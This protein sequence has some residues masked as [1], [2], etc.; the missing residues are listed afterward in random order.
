[1]KWL[2]NALATS[3]GKKFVMGLTGLLLCGFL[4]VHL[5]GNLL[6]YVGAD[7]YNHYAHSLHE[8]KALL[9]VAEIGLLLLFLAHIVLAIRLTM[10]NRAARKSRYLVQVSK[11]DGQNFNKL[12]G[13][14]AWMFVSG[15][16]VLGFILLHLVDFRF[17][18]RSELVYEGKEPFQKALMVL[19]TPL[20]FGVYIVG[21]LFLGWHL[22]HGFAS[23]FQSLGINHPKYNGLI[24]GVSLV[25][26]IAIALGF[27]SFPLW[28]WLSNHSSAA[29]L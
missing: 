1:M 8:Q 4:V 25:F 13:A 23:A 29:G 2:V 10:E 18:L 27:A 28:A 3:I 11:I 22:S 16:I 17:E 24:R 7:A 26:A 21:A 20:T 14:D 5:A 9:L 19:Q 15:S 12:A 6:L